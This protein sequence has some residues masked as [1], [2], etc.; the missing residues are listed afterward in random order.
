MESASPV[1]TSN[2]ELNTSRINNIHAFNNNLS[3]FARQATAQS[4][5]AKPPSGNTSRLLEKTVT[6]IKSKK[7]SNKI[8]PH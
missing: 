4:I 2:T 5:I 1:F 6:E 7:C 3:P 8:G